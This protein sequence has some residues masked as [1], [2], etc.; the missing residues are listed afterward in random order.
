MSF[1]KHL[2]TIDENEENG[3][4]SDPSHKSGDSHTTRQSGRTQRLSQEQK[5]QDKILIIDE[6][7][8]SIVHH[9]RELGV[10]TETRK[11]VV[12]EYKRIMNDGSMDSTTKVQQLTSLSKT[13]YAECGKWLTELRPCLAPDEQS[14]LDDY[15]YDFYYDYTDKNKTG[16]EWYNDY[17]MMKKIIKQRLERLKQRQ[18]SSS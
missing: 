1:N 17:F 2:H 16:S 11:S 18:G 8:R 4:T 12:D 9:A 15:Y 5:N 7:I 10:P 13:A 3:G 14:K 6:D